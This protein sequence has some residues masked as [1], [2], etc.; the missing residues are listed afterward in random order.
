MAYPDPYRRA[1]SS[2]HPSYNGYATTIPIRPAP[3]PG[4][5]YN[6]A[7]PYQQYPPSPTSTSS[8]TSTYSTS[9]T[10]PNNPPTYFCLWPNCTYSCSRN[11]DLQRHYQNVHNRES[12]PLVDCWVQGCHRRGAYGFTRKDKMVEHVREVHKVDVPK[13]GSSGGGR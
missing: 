9:P 5:P 1:S 3:T 13:R 10:T 4:Y 6:A 11:A 12:A 8:P 2:H 7:Y